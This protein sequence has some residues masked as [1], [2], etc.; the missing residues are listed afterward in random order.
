MDDLSKINENKNEGKFN[1][2]DLKVTV[3]KYPLAKSKNMFESFLIIG[4]DDIYITEKILKTALSTLEITK[5]QMNIIEDQINYEMTNLINFYCRDLP[6][7]L[8]TITSDF[9]GEILDQK[10]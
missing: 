10:K 1:L 8:N 9:S 7:I 3:E 5:Y 4:Y 2:N 6:T